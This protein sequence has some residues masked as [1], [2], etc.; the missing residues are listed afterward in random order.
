MS[1]KQLIAFLDDYIERTA[2]SESDRTGLGEVRD[3]LARR[4][5]V[6]R[7]RIHYWESITERNRYYNQRNRERRLRDE[8]ASEW[9]CNDDK[10]VSE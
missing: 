7:P 4:L 5:N 6:G 8:K 9:H 3:S 10:T 1:I 2:L